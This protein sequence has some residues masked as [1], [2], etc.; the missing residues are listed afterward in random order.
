[1]AEKME[2]RTDLEEVNKDLPRTEVTVAPGRSMR[3]PGAVTKAMVNVGG[4]NFAE[5]VIDV[6]H[7]AVLPGQ[8]IMVFTKDVPTLVAMGTIYP[9]TE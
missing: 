7:R 9:P 1:M 8:K 4:G 2:K 6:V 5:R 3:D